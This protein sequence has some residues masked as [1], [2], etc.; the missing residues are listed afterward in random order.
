MS[1]GLALYLIFFRE[2]GRPSCFSGCPSPSNVT[3]SQLYD[4]ARDCIIQSV[5]YSLMYDRR[6]VTLDG[7][8]QP[9]K[10]EGRPTSR[11]KIK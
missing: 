9:L 3:T 5:R 4:Y 1:E 2:V 8:G 10:Q 7:D 11:K 6:V